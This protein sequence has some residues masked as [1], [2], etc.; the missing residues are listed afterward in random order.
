MYEFICDFVQIGFVS[1]GALLPLFLLNIKI[2]NSPVRSRK[3][4]TN[5]PI[6]YGNNGESSSTS[7]T[8]FKMIWTAKALNI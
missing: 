3:K 6:L 1:V 5:K 2:R 4:K 7:H 8:G